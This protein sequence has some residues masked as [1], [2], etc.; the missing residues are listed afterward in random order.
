MA[1]SRSESDAETLRLDVRGHVAPRCG[2]APGA[3]PRGGGPNGMALSP[4]AAARAPAVI[5]F[6]ID[7][8]TPFRLRVESDSWTMRLVDQPP[9]RATGL[10][11]LRD[12][13][14][15]DLSLEAPAAGLKAQCGRASLLGGGCV[16]TGARGLRSAKPAFA[17]EARLSVTPSEAAT[18]S[19]HAAGLYR[20]TLRIIVEA[21]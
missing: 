11:A 21:D 1:N 5:D 10:G 4:D 3:A 17:A 15:Y 18:P 13:V 19:T 20:D 9:V 6:S 12:W 7:C 2:F 14:G 8:N 16:L